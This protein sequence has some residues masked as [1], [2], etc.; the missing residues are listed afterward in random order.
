M[1]G[2]LIY[3]ILII[4]GVVAVIFISKLFSNRGRSW[5]ECAE[6]YRL[7]FKE[8]TEEKGGESVYT[9]RLR[10]HYRTCLISIQSTRSSSK[11]ETLIT[12]SYPK[13]LITN[14]SSY[15]EGLLTRISRGLSRQLGPQSS[16]GQ[17]FY[18][19]LPSAPSG[20]GTEVQREFNPL[21]KERLVQLMI[22]CGTKPNQIEITDAYIMYRQPG[23]A[24]DPAPHFH[25][26]DEMINFINLLENNVD[27]LL[28]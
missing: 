13:D 27:E 8:G 2:I 9:N 1:Q 26:I 17:P 16:S 25:I 20:K 7:N 12:V 23:F 5:K 19:T 28:I 10:G 24:K 6:M 4:A 14:L 18:I 21:L 15:P 11:D 3:A 22:I